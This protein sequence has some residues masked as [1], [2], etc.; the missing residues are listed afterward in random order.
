MKE[1]VNRRTQSFRNEGG[2]TKMNKRKIGSDCTVNEGRE[3]LGKSR[4]R[5]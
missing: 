1:S 2:T 4:K 5:M 3:S